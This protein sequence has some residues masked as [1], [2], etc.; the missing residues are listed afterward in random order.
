[1]SRLDALLAEAHAAL[2]PDRYARLMDGVE[3]TRQASE[4]G[5]RFAEMMVERALRDRGR[6]PVEVCDC[7]GSGWM[8]G[9]GGMVPCADCAPEQWRR[10]QAGHLGCDD[11]E[12]A[13]CANQSS[14][15]ATEEEL[16]PQ[17]SEPERAGDIAEVLPLQGGER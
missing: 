3:T 7:D 9:D 4:W 8:P 11:A 16:L 5:D 17:V 2:P 12:C 15:R 14:G 10:W 6:D 1:M 13:E